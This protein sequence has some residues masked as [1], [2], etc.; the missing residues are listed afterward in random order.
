MGECKLAMDQPGQL[1]SFRAPTASTLPS[2]EPDKVSA[3]WLRI[4]PVVD[5]LQ[6]KDGCVYT[7][8]YLER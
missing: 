8:G 1:M 2:F 3:C 4:T 7:K 6:M 5:F